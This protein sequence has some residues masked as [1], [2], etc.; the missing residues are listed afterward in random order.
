MFYTENVKGMMVNGMTLKCL[1]KPREKINLVNLFGT[2]LNIHNKMRK[3]TKSLQ[4][5][6]TIESKETK[7]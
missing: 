4:I 5:V 1:L 3:V 7:K 6:D 2:Q